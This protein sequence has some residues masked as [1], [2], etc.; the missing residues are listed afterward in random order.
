MRRVPSHGADQAI[1]QFRKVID[2]E[3]GF[4]AAHFE[5]GKLLFQKNSLPEAIAQFR[6]AV[7][8]D[9]KLGAARYQLGLALTRAGQRTEGAAELE[10]ARA[11]IEEE[12]KLEMAGQ[13]MG[14]ART[15][16]ENGQN[17]TAV[18]RSP[19]I[20]PSASRIAGGPRQLAAGA[21]PGRPKPRQLAPPARDSAAPPDDPATIKLFEDYV[22]RQQFKELEPLVIDYLKAN[23]N[24]WWGH[25]VL[26]YAQFGQ[27]RIGD[28]IASLAKSLQLNLKNAEAHQ[29]LGRNLMVI[30]RFDAAQTELEQAVKLKPQ[31]AEIRYDLAKIHSANDNYPPAKRELEEAIRL[32]PS[33]MEAYDALGFV[34]EAMGD[35]AAALSF[36]KK[37]AEMNEARGG[38]FA[39]PYVNLAAYYNRTGRL[40]A[41]AGVCA[42]GDSTESEIRRR[43][44]PVGQSARAQGQVARSGGSPQ[45][46][47]CR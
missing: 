29:L 4:A 18:D 15:A 8:L 17:D 20:G 36:Y 37:A 32:D 13:L 38:N 46:G 40:E 23:P 30:G 10:Q 35:D 22:R 26:G 11:A 9:P 16:M 24:S 21:E 42:E 25:Y 3:P 44:F 1:A 34:M 5:F 19:T 41:G 12:R 33:Y 45:P 7:K 43:Q 28:S 27:Q 39:S 14:E 31:S 6:E 47:D 2:L